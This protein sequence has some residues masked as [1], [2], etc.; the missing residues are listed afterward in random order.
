MSLE[1]AILELASAIRYH[2]DNKVQEPTPVTGKPKDKPK[3]KAKKAKEPEPEP[4]DLLDEPEA[5]GDKLSLSDVKKELIW[6]SQEKDHAAVKNLLSDIA[7][8]AVLSSVDE[9]HYPA[10]VAKVQKMIG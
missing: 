8:T 1:N 4:K 3:P 9:E 2:A 5:E 7:G 10:I 6:L